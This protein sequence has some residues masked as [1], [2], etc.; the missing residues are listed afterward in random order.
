MRGNRLP[1][2][3]D[4]EI[5][6]P[7]I[8]LIMTDQQRFDTIGALGFSVMRTP[9]MDRLAREGVSFD[10][11]FVAA[12]VCVP[13]RAS[14]FTGLYPHA[15]GVFRNADSWC[16]SWVGRFQGAG[17]HTVSVGK[18]HTTPLAALCGFDQRIVVENKVRPLLLDQPHGGDFDD[19]DKFLGTTGV[20]KPSED[21][22]H[23]QP[24]YESA[25]GAFEWHLE[26]AYH[27]DVVVGSMAEWFVR[28]RESPAPLLLVLGFPG[29]HPPYDPPRRCID[30]YDDVDLPVP[31]VTNEELNG[32][33]PP[34]KGYRDQMRNGRN[35]G[36]LWTAR[37]P[38]KQL[39]RLRRHYAANVTLIDDQIGRV[40]SAMGDRGYLDDA[41]VVLTSDHGDCLGDHGHIQKWTMY[42]EVMK[43]PAIVWSPS[44]LP[45]GKRF[46]Q[47]I[48]HFDL[49]PTLFELAGLSTEGRRSAES[50]LPIVNGDGGGRHY[51]FAEQIRDNLAR[52][53]TF[54]TMIRSESWKLVHYL[55]QEWGELYDL[56]AHPAE[57]KNLWTDPAS[58]S[59]KMALLD[60]IR[61]WRIR[62]TYRHSYEHLRLGAPGDI[63]EPV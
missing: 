9:V 50:L 21:Y 16:E 46:T 60:E 38:R 33:P 59:V 47:L 24:D 19:Y 1:T 22:L 27:P 43:V 18:M 49:G 53:I 44:R 12:P 26:E 32:Q 2:L 17:Y 28:T 8:L 51:V 62:E 4:R 20:K 6:A 36:I 63:S 5:P 10:S 14:F 39:E 57:T 55:D 34:H 40:L 23:D 31:R 54:C 11:C 42:D 3:G 35:D 29:P 13:S 41:I 48:Q 30:L 25:L 45:Q 61:D 37:P 56:K 15:S 7:N 58:E 52:E